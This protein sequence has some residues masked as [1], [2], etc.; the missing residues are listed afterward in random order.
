[1]FKIFLCWSLLGWFYAPAMASSGTLPIALNI[2][3]HTEF[4]GTVQNDTSGGMRKLDFAPTVGLGTEIK[5][6]EG[7]SFL[8]LPEFNWVLPQKAGSSQIIKNLFM[9][10]A[11]IG[12]LAFNWLR[13]R[14]GTSLLLANQHGRGGST[15]VNNGNTQSKFYYP[16][17]NRS[18]WNNTLD[19]GIEF[20]PTFLEEPQNWNL[21]LQTYTYSVFREQQRQISYTLFWTYYW[22]KP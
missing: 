2:G 19:F 4:F 10:R 16:S 22:G 21:R 6:Q 5:F 12:Y 18:S 14:M 8:F 1:M 3:S 13:L 11:D 15:N 17:E 20:F 9:F 7:S